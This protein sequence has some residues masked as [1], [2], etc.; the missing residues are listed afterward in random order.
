MLFSQLENLD[1]IVQEREK[2]Y[3]NYQNMFNTI[4]QYN[5]KIQDISNVSKTNYS[6]FYLLLE[7]L[8]KRNSLIK[9]LKTIISHLNF[10]MFHYTILQWVENQFT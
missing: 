7:N 8:E 4:S 5:V 9:F 3:K 10:I 6:S 1:Y 2:I